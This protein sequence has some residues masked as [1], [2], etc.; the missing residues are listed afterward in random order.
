[1][2]FFFAEKPGQEKEMLTDFLSFLEE[3]PELTLFHYSTTRFDQR[4]LRTRL[5]ENRL[6][7][8]TQI[9]KSIDVG[10]QVE[11]CVAT[12]TT[13]NELSAIARW[14]GYAFAHPNLDGK[15]IA[16]TCMD[17][18][19][20]EKEVPKRVFRYNQDDV[21]A[22]RKIVNWMEAEGPAVEKIDAETSDKKKYAAVADKLEEID[23]E[24]KIVL[25]G[26]EKENVYE[27]MS[28]MYQRFGPEEVAVRYSEEEPGAWKA[29]VHTR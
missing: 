7:V 27:L 23:D 10:L 11:K 15:D 4:I 13:S 17:C 26:L 29:I 1:M 19:E 8:P 20:N 16:N 5:Q 6:P 28:V 24:R 9:E 25:S 14:V 3:N 22:V 12:P 18:S 2:K 21:L